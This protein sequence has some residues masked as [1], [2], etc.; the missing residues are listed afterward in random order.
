MSTKSSYEK[1]S[2]YIHALIVVIL[3][4]GFRFIPAPEPITAYGMQIIGIFLA[5]IWGW[6]FC[7]LL[8]P[9]LLA[10][11][12][13]GLTEFGNEYA[14]W[15]AAFGNQTAVLTLVS[16][17]LFGA[18]QATK[19]T[20]WM[21][22]TLT[23]LKFAQGKPWIL[24]FLLLFVPLILGSIISGVVVIL[25]MISIFDG[26]FR[27]MSLSK[28][29]KYA[30]LMIIGV[31]FFAG[32]GMVMFPFLGWDLM[33]IGTVSAATGV[34][35]N[36]TNFIIVVW[37]G[38]FIF[39]VAYVLMMKYIF[40]CDASKLATIKVGDGEDTKLKK[41][42]KYL[43]YL[44]AFYLAAATFVGLVS[45][46]TGIGYISSSMGV[47]GVTLLVLVL[48]AFIKTEEGPLLN[49]EKCTN[50]VSWDMYFLIVAALFIANQLTAEN[51]GISAW[52]VQTLMPL[53]DNVN[54]IMFYV[55]ISIITVIA[56]NV[57]NNMAMGFTLL[58]VVSVLY[59]AGMQFN[60]MVAAVLIT[61][62]CLF[63]F[64]FPASSIGGAIIHA[65]EWCDKKSIYK[66]VSISLIL[67]TVIV[68]AIVTLLG[69]ALL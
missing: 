30:V 8:W 66:Y 11:M 45:G 21:V 28:G 60:P 2:R 12:A 40:K 49:T 17:L 32:I 42:Q 54:E 53:L 46:T 22:M 37:P 14:V 26:L 65:N 67:G 18:L 5:V 68:V 43:L 58:S 63:G 31:N 25:F 51:T 38:L 36:Y 4:F 61:I 62:L 1:I 33:T 57:G 29:D 10:L 48:M 6:S 41:N 19:T 56:T 50:F 3:M 55:I 47:Y 24:S 9:S 44:T 69:S 39:C 59:N 20:D 13:V 16:M 34:G 15:A 23:N 64:L 27:K 52:T 7:G 35:L